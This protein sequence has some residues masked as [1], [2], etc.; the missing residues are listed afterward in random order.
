MRVQRARVAVSEVLSF[1]LPKPKSRHHER[2][3]RARIFSRTKKC[4]V[5]LT[6]KKRVERRLVSALPHSPE[7]GRARVPRALHVLAPRVPASA[8]S[9]AAR[10]PLSTRKPSPSRRFVA[11]KRTNRRP[12]REIRARREEDPAVSRCPPCFA[13]CSPAWR[14]PTQRRGWCTTTPSGTSRSW[15][16]RRRRTITG[17]ASGSAPAHLLRARRGG[18]EAESVVRQTKEGTTK[19][20]GQMKAERMRAELALGGVLPAGKA[21]LAPRGEKRGEMTRRVRR[22]RT[23]ASGF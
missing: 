14:G 1:L 11:K 5:K 17:T 13:T 8:R 16:A 4:H 20:A 21:T 12:P 9:R 3:A 2:N 6:W 18:R 10:A 15:A 22:P 19:P 7:H 23:P